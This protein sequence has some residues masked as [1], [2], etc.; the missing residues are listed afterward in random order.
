MSTP[1]TTPG[2]PPRTQADPYRYGWRY[3]KKADEKGEVAVVRVPLRYEDL[4]HPQEDDFIVQNLLHDHD[5]AYLRSVLA[6][7]KK[8]IQGAEVF[9][10]VRVDWEVAG[11]EPLGPDLSLFLDVNDS[12]RQGFV[13]TLRVKHLGVKCALVIEV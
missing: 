3:V 4:L 13:G 5:C 12:W 7:A 2:T 1:T 10:D 11:L 8:R 9:H 6:R